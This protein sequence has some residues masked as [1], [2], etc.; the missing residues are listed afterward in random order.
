MRLLQPENSMRNPDKSLFPP[1]RINQNQ[2]LFRAID[3]Y[4]KTGDSA[5]RTGET[6]IRRSLMAAF[7]LVVSAVEL[8]SKLNS[9]AV[10]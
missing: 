10:L 5:N 8:K 6:A 3:A 9:S 4:G 7:F 2:L 1:A